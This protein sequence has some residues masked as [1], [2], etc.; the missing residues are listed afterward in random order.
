MPTP[1]LPP[2]MLPR[3]ITLAER[4]VIIREALRGAS[5]IVLQELLNGVQDRVVVAVT[6]LAML[7]LVKRREVA[8]EQATPWGPIVVRQ[9]TA[10]ERGG[11]SSEALAAAPMDES[12]ESFA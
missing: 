4:A 2:E 8:V 12:M 3:S 11:T 10:E 6:F 9:T 7:E 5:P 1:P